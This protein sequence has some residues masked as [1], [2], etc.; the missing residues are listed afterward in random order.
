M[1]ENIAEIGVA[2]RRWAAKQLHPA[3]RA[4]TL[5]IHERW[6][7]SGGSATRVTSG[8]NHGST[9]VRFWHLADMRAGACMSAIWGKADVTRT[10]Q[11]VCL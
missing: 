8:E 2:N 11:D 9:N 1:R 3:R 4:Q 7:F 10:S 6:A 5:L